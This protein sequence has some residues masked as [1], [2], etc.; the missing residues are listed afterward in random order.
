MKLL[1][2]QRLGI[3]NEDEGEPVK[4]LTY[5]GRG[6]ER[7]VWAL[8]GGVGIWVR[9]TEGAGYCKGNVHR[10]K[11]NYQYV[12]QVKKRIPGSV[13]WGFRHFA[14]LKFG[15]GLWTGEAIDCNRRNWREG[16]KN[17]NKESAQLTLLVQAYLTSL[18]G[19]KVCVCVLWLIAAGDSRRRGLRGGQPLN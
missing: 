11:G 5:W 4:G 12:D 14:I 18:E 9:V 13:K 19:L 17:G 7:N 10:Q 16:C 3:E 6:N 8:A 2:G 1:R 15:Q